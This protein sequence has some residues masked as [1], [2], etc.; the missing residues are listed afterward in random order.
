MFVCAT[1]AGALNTT[2]FNNV[3]LV[4]PPQL[5]V[6]LVSPADGT[7]VD[8]TGTTISW[9]QG[10]TSASYDVY[11]G[12]TDPP[13][14]AGNQTETSFDTGPLDGGTTYYYQIDAVEADGTTVHAGEVRSLKTMREGTG[15]ILY[16]IW[17]GIGGTAV[18]DLTGNALYPDNPSSSSELSL[19]ETP[20][21][22]AD[23]F[24]GRVHGY[25]HPETSGDY[26]F[27]TA[28]DDASDLLL[29]TDD[30]PANAVTIAYEDSWAAARDWQDGNEKS[31]PVPLVGGEKYYISAIYK[32]GG[33]GDNLAVAWEGPDSPTRDVISGYYLSPYVNMAPSNPSPI[34]GSSAVFPDEAILSWSAAPTA[35]SY[36]VYLNGELAGSTTETSLD[37]DLVYGTD[38]VWSVDAVES[39]GTT[40]HSSNEWAFSTIPRG[41]GAMTQEIWWGIGGGAV[42]DLTANE[43]Y[44]D[45][46]S[47]VRLI[48]S[49]ETQTGIGDNYGARVSGYLHVPATG[50][51]TFWI[52]TDDGSELWLSTDE[53]PANGVLIAQESG[54]SNPR[55]WKYGE[56]MSDPVALTGGELY[57]VEALHKE[58]GGGDN[59]AVAWEGPGI[60]FSVISGDYVSITPTRPFAAYGFNPVDGATGVDSSPTLRWLP[61]DAAASYDVSFNGESVGNT[62]ER[63]YAPGQLVLGET[64]TWQ[65]DTIDGEGATIGSAAMS[66]TVSDNLVIDDFDSYYTAP[67]NPGSAGLWGYYPL[68][69]DVLDYSSNGHDGTLV[70]EPNVIDGPPGYGAALEFSPAGGDDYVDLGTLDPSADTGQ[71]SVSLWLNWNG[72]SGEWQGLIGKRDN[73]AADDMMWHLECNANDGTLG[74]NRHSGQSVGGYG[75]PVI[76]EWEHCAF[77]TDGD[78]G[79][80]YRDG[81]LVGSG[82]FT[83]GPDTEAA[84]LFG[85][86]NG[87]GW[88]PFNGAL[89]DVRIYNRTLSD[90]EVMHLAGLEAQGPTIDETW[91]EAGLVDISG[92]DGTMAV[93]TFSWPGLPYYLGETGRVLPFADLTTGGGKALSIWFR[94]DPGNVV[95]YMYAVLTDADGNSGISVYDEPDDLQSADWREWNIDMRD[96]DGVDESNAA[97]LAIGL[98]GLDGGAATDMMVFDD[99]RVYTG[100]C[101][102]DI[103]KPLADLNNDCVVNIDDAHIIAGEW[104]PTTATYTVSGNGADIW[105]EADQFHY[106]YQEVTGDCEISAR[107]AEMGPGTNGWAKAGV[108]IRETTDDTS[109]HMMM[110]MTDNQGGGIAF[111]GRQETAG[112]STSYHDEIQATEPHWV[113]LTREGN[114]ITAYHSANGVDWELFTDS[115]PDGAHSNPIDVPMAETVTVGLAMTSHADGQ[116]RT[117]KFDNVIINGV[118]SPELT[119]VDVGNT[120]PGESSSELILSPADLNQDASVDFTDF[121]IML[122]EWLVEELWPY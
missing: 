40:K 31:A 45:N 105:A 88:N 86:N 22:R 108:M 21:N 65:V 2:V 50:D 79:Q 64:Y 112:G 69:G 23:N 9:M 117:A 101:M 30:D 122:D 35:A 56:Q 73:W 75:V 104:G 58:G 109:K 121:F 37:P 47:E 51:Y 17:D 60:P 83:L 33:G 63:S 42:A 90:A 115:A 8:M 106:M 102:P 91:T 49:F 12:T 68:N 95:Q 70:G 14:L 80:L 7:V 34:S 97:T 120:T 11:F 96:F 55:D 3:G 20:T 82:T 1:N 10:D 76:G 5:P 116:L 77:S 113:K 6:W 53:D 25:L 61:G 32:E 57:Y 66:F 103:I 93:E 67:K 81:E 99:I 98:A 4:A 62:T 84:L 71:L 107:V 118:L 46:P 44:P 26:T 43:N 18:G 52:A 114:T 94:G 19:F 36:D 119:G 13:P 16:E 89:D 87:G 38:Y 85:A 24:G 111:Q 15:T 59:L 28:S 78:T 41:P 74:A 92:G 48:N 110:V 29:S 72:I 39:D 100:R 54:W 27:W